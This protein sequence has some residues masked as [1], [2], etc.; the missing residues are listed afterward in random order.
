[1]LEYCNVVM[2]GVDLEIVT[3]QMKQTREQTIT[4]KEELNCV[5][6]M[7]DGILR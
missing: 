3:Q 5:L 1:M 7:Q 6:I 4:C 2:F